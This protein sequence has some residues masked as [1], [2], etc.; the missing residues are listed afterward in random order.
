M[1]DD[2]FIDEIVGLRVTSDGTVHEDEDVQQ[3]YTYTNDDEVSYLKE[4]VMSLKATVEAMDKKIT[5]LEVEIERMKSGALNERPRTV[6][7]MPKPYAMR[8]TTSPM[9]RSRTTDTN[10]DDDTESFSN[11]SGVRSESSDRPISSYMA[12]NTDTAVFATPKPMAFKNNS[13]I[14]SRGYDNKL[15]LWGTIFTSLMVSC[16]KKYIQTTGETGHV[17]DEVILMKT[18]T[19]IV[20][21]LYHRAK[22][23]ELPAVQSH[24]VA[25]LSNLF[26]RDSKSE[27]PIS[28]PSTWMSLRRSPDG[29]SC[30]SVIESIITAAKMVPEA[31][32]HPISRL[33]AAVD[34]PMIVETPKGAT[35]AIPSDT[36]ISMTPTGFETFCSWL[37]K[38]SLKVYVK[39]RLNG[40]SEVVAINKMVSSMRDTDLF[41]NKNLYRGR[42]LIS[43]LSN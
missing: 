41:D 22:F 10:R 8:H 6:A 39:Y 37:K 42:E 4:A 2:N 12:R 17:I 20:G 32:I 26:K 40:D 34:Q 7:T 5:G 21:D 16:M 19:R 36:R 29:N 23:A 28:Y 9:V 25:L 33:I 1:S 13:A 43:G 24:E 27:V 31:M 30:L 35:Y 15:N 11:V 3:D 18:Y 38:E 14:S